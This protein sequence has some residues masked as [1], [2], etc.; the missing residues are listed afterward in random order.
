MFHYHHHF[1]STSENWTVLCCIWHRLISSAAGASDWNSR[2]TAPPTHVVDIDIDIDMETSLPAHTFRP[3]D[4]IRRGRSQDPPT[5]KLCY[6]RLSL[7][8]VPII[9]LHSRSNPVCPSRCDEFY[10]HSSGR[11][12]TV[13]DRFCLSLHSWSGC[14]CDKTW[15]IATSVRQRHSDIWRLLAAQCLRVFVK[16]QRVRQRCCKLDA[17]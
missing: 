14:T 11:S 13:L 10:T 6:R 8:L 12:M 7:A 16:C 15:T 4:S 9:G 17:F 2:L 3:L 5:D 1:Q